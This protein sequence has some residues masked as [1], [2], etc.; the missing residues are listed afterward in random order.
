MNGAREKTST[1][2][3]LQVKERHIRSRSCRS[4]CKILQRVKFHQNVMLSLLEVSRSQAHTIELR[5]N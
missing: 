2:S 1:L 4:L 5:C 3:V